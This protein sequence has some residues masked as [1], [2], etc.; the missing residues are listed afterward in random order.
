LFALNLGDATTATVVGQLFAVD[1]AHRIIAGSRMSEEHT[2][3]RGGG[4]YGVMVGKGDAETLLSLQAVEDDALEGVVRAGGIT[5]GRAEELEGVSA[6][7]TAYGTGGNELLE[8]LSGSLGKTGADSMGHETLLLV[9]GLFLGGGQDGE[10]GQRAG[11]LLVEEVGEAMIMSDGL[12]LTAQHGQYGSVG[13]ND[14]IVSAGSSLYLR[15]H[16][17]LQSVG[18]Y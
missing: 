11:L 10:E 5:E 9:G 3:D 8:P 18:D 2:T 6:A 17:E 13:K 7:R 4:L 14:V 12:A 15:Q 16:S 1:A